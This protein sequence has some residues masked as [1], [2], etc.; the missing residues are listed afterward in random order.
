VMSR[1]AQRRRAHLGAEG[2]L[3]PARTLRLRAKWYALR[4]DGAVQIVERTL[5]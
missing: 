5:A 3:E 2:D 4:V 1:L